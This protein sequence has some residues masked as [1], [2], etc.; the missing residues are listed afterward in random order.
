MSFFKDIK[1]WLT[2]ILCISNYDRK[3]ERKFW[4]MR[5]LYE[6]V[7]YINRKRAL[8]LENKLQEKYQLK[9]SR[10]AKIGE[11]FQI[12]HP[13]GIRIGKTAEIGDNCKVYPFFVAMAAVK[14]D[15]ELIRNHIRRHP[16]IGN[17]CLLGSKAS[18][19]G[20]V[21]IGDDVTIGGLCHRH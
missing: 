19:I 4:K 15:R 21:T 13:M 7:G 16:K 11:N 10:T 14:G 12:R 1:L 18:V 17:D 20:P 9:V 2:D 6:K 8:R 3:V 5:R